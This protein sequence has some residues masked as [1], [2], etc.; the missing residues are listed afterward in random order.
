M[1][2]SR[3]AKGLEDLRRSLEY[4]LLPGLRVCA[5]QGGGSGFLVVIREVFASVEFLGAL[6][7]GYAGQMDGRRR[8]IATG[9]KSIS[10]LEEV[11]GPSIRRIGTIAD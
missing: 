7:G 8:R 4:G 10:F 3:V 11:L 2:L 9:P 5:Q 6:Y 1:D